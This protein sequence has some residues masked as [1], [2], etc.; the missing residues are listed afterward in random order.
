MS[1]TGGQSPRDLVFTTVVWDGNASVADLQAHIERMKRQ[2][3]RLR[4][5]WPENMNELISRAM[6]QLGHH[7]T[8]QP[9]QPNGLLRMELSR[10]GEL[11][12][13]P[14]A[15]SLRNE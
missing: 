13:E 7:A 11:N 5:Q 6:S 15:F 3:H 4:I 1:E 10:N 12:I 8:G 14:R 2:A 9:R